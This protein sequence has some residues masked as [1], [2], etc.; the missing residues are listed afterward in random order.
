MGNENTDVRLKRKAI[1]S[2]S[3]NIQLNSRSPPPSTPERHFSRNKTF[4]CERFL[5][6]S[7]T[8]TYA[9]ICSELDV[10]NGKC[11]YHQHVEIET[12]H[13]HPKKVGSHQIHKREW[14]GGAR[15][16]EV[17]LLQKI[18]PNGIFQLFETKK[19]AREIIRERPIAQCKFSQWPT[20]AGDE[21]GWYLSP[22]RAQFG[23]SQEGVNI[24]AFIAHFV[25]LNSGQIRLA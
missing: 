17:P 19:S 20:Y 18:P 16:K 1:R 12:F 7:L 8:P 14:G 10:I 22:A 23:K 9:D 5:S 24:S 25:M 4:R 15:Q 11:L 6:K 13:K 21:P 3:A 2:H